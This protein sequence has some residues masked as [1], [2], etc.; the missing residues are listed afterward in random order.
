VLQSCPG[1]QLCDTRGGRTAGAGLDPAPEC[2][3]RSPGESFCGELIRVQC[4]PDLLTS[5][6]ATC[7]SVSHCLAGAGAGC[8]TCIEGE[9]G[10]AGATLLSC[11]LSTHAFVVE[12]TCASAGECNAIAG[13]CGASSCLSGQHACLAGVLSVCNASL[14]GF[15]PIVDCGAMGR[16]CDAA[17]VQ[18]DLCTP[19]TTSCDGASTVKK[20]NPDGQSFSYSS[21]PS[22]A[23]ACVG[24]GTC[25]GCSTSSDCPPST[26]ECMVADCVASVCGDSPRAA[27]SSCTGGVCDGSGSCSE[28]KPG[29]KRCQSAI[30]P[31]TCG[32]TGTWSADPPC[33]GSEVCSGGVCGTCA[34]GTADC[35]GSI[36]NGCE[37][38]LKEDVLNCGACGNVCS[39]YHGTPA[40]LIGQCEMACAAPYGNCDG[41]ASNGCEADKSTSPDHCGACGQACTASH[42]ATVTCTGGQ[43]SGVCASGWGD[44]NGDKRI[45]GCETP[46]DTQPTRCGGCNNVCSTA[47]VVATACSGGLCSGAC[48][49]GW[50]DCN[51][52][53]LTDGCETDIAS[54][55]TACGSCGSSCS[56][57]HVTASCSG[58]E[59]V[60]ACATGYLDCDGDKRFNGCEI[61]GRSDAAHCG[62]CDV[63][64]G[65]GSVCLAGSC[66]PPPKPGC[67]DVPSNCGLSGNGS[68]CESAL[69]NQASFSQGRESGDADYAPAGLTTQSGESPGRSATVSTFRLDTYEVTVGRFR[70]FVTASVLGWKPAAGAGKHTH[71]SGGQ[72]SGEP[73]WSSAWDTNLSTSFTTWDS[74]LKC[75]NYSTWTTTPGTAEARP[76][77]CINFYAAYAFC[78]WDGGFLPTE[79]EWELAASGGEERV[80][81]WSVPATSATIDGNYASYGSGGGSCYGDG[82][83]ACAST[84]LLVVGSRPSGAGKWGHADLG[85]NVAEWVLDTYASYPSASCSDCAVTGS[86]TTRVV[87]GGSFYSAK[88][89]LRAAFR[90][91]ATDT[92]KSGYNGIRCARVP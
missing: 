22:N 44:C 81:P 32:G 71:L 40:C 56:A 29:Q 53:K 51:N 79:A 21:C 35:D 85:G 48:Q 28:C 1:P 13:I 12:A 63:G 5:T 11:D 10:C 33:S 77:N 31:E 75:S 2:V 91:S 26:Q 37:V 55:A 88:D 86:S 92:T 23:P 80:F 78:I 84:D 68:C 6:S 87:R 59:C 52:D 64:C 46:L 18:C 82:A 36:V 20:C 3:G 50:G 41:N 39:T 62:S 61:D 8:A 19:G 27:G 83:T 74:Q 24:A 90:G 9:H 70:P 76:V 66:A 4:G 49:S 69:V 7:K 15:D 60:G 72:L 73:G 42:M 17:G 34:S 57:N 14:T 45:D 58:G 54:T 25:G 30:Q 47:H 38:P 65:A 43:C 89:S 16:I 67:Q